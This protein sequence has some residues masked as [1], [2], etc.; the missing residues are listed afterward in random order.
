MIIGGI[1]FVLQSPPFRHPK[2]GPLRLEGEKV[3]LV[4]AASIRCS[5]ATSSG[6]VATFFDESVD[7]VARR[8]EQTATA[9]PELTTEEDLITEL[10]ISPLFTCARLA[11][12]ELF[13]WGVLPYTQ[14]RRLIDRCRSRLKKH[15]FSS[16]NEVVIGASVCLK[17]S[18]IYHAG[19]VGFTLSQGVPKVGTL[20]SSAWSFIDTCSF[21]VDNPPSL[22]PSCSSGPQPQPPGTRGGGGGRVTRRSPAKARDKR[23]NSEED[24]GGRATT[25]SRKR[26]RCELE[27]SSGDEGS[28]L[29]SPARSPSGGGGSEAAAETVEEWYIKDVIFLEDGGNL[30]I[31]K[32]V[33]VDGSYC[34]VRFPSL[35]PTRHSKSGSSQAQG[36]TAAVTPSTG[37]N[38]SAPSSAGPPPT[39]AP[40]ATGPQA[41]E[42]AAEDAFED[43]RLLRKDELQVLH[44]SSTGSVSRMPDCFQNW[45]RRIPVAEPHNIMAFA[46]DS[47]GIHAIS[48]S[49][50]GGLS[51]TLLNLTS[52]KAD[53]ESPF[54]TDPKGFI[55]PRNIS[56][57]CAGDIASAESECLSL[58]LD[59]N[60]TLYPIAKDC[61]EAIRDPWWLDLP[62]VQCLSS[63]VI[64][65]AAGG[66]GGAS[67]AGSSAPGSS[68]KSSLSNRA[69]ASIHAILFRRPSLISHILRCDL[70][71]VIEVLAEAEAL[72]PT[73]AEQSAPDGEPNRE[74]RSPTSPPPSERLIQERCDG[75]RNI[76]HAAVA[77]TA[78]TSNREDG[79]SGSGGSGGGGTRS[80]GASPGDY[81]YDYDDQLRSYTRDFARRAQRFGGVGGVN[82]EDL[83]DDPPPPPP[84]PFLSQG[85]SQGRGVGR[86]S[87]P[88]GDDTAGAEAGKG[89]GADGPPPMDRR[90]QAMAILTALLDKP[91]LRPHLYDLLSARNAE[92][93]TPFM[94]AV[95]MRAF[96]AAAKVFDAA[97]RLS[98][99]LALKG[100]SNTRF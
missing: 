17:T 4:A 27:L 76:L 75:N 85:D 43:C 73:S 60:R 92:S 34:A 78:P 30:P 59:G 25:R 10:K 11:S 15:H 36:G 12:G 91:C 6:K 81:A 47:S 41:E 26:R 65:L 64:P 99:D 42:K 84:P 33:K 80:G 71:R 32:V 1:S 19:A 38:S 88:G 69:A 39:A 95:S 90:A 67:G 56:L 37:T 49:S 44:T 86:G 52:G 68:S 98:L 93:Q 5:V 89:R 58:M 21:R 29:S 13:W 79:P 94:Q 82:L 53:R 66:A 54:P 31:G 72:A 87:S 96:Q 3:T 62:P 45:P 14:R 83:M 23:S 46:V 24:A 97:H 70:Q 55:A 57:R 74:Q 7:A 20:M 63:G 40:P 51:Y 8:M 61:T 35:A 16:A 2:T 18:P 50:D 22:P 48:R 9:H 28:N 100:S 77:M